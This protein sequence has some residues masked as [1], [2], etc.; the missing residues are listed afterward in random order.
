MS[1]N[2]PIFAQWIEAKR[3]E[4]EA[5]KLR[6]EIEDLMIEGFDIPEDFEGT[7]N[8]KSEGF[9]VKIIGRMNRKIDS[10]KV[11]ELAAE[12]GLSEHLSSLFRW[13]PEIKMSAWKSAD[14]S[15]T[16]P[17]LGAITTTPGRPSI[18]V[19]ENEK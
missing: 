3:N 8:I 9:D 19:T 14:A 18:L 6:R 7:K 17:L 10:D 16:D 2:P 5:Q 1:N 4:Q 11:Q 12:A 15:I 13:K